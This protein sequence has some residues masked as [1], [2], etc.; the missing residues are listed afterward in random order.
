MKKKTKQALLK[1]LADGLEKL[2]I[3]SLLLGLFQFNYYALGV[4][5]LSLSLTLMLTYILEENE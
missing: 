4:A 5:I 2:S 3:G 1:R